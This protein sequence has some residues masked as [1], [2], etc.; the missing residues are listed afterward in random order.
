MPL[1]AEAAATPAPSALHTARPFASTT[2]EDTPR[3][4]TSAS[5]AEAD[6]TSAVRL[7]SDT[8]REATRRNTSD[9]HI[10]PADMAGAC[11]CALTA[12]CTP[13]HN[14]LRIATTLG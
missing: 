9:L 13:S 11:V 12:C 1:D 5:L 6:N 2:R 7:L 8:L 10:E 14:H 4:D 3:R